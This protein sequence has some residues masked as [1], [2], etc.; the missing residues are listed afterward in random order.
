MLQ[1]NGFRTH[2]NVILLN[3]PILDS[4]TVQYRVIQFP[5]SQEIQAFSYDEKRTYDGSLGSAF[6]DPLAPKND[7]EPPIGL[8]Y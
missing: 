4:L 3:T 2:G 7:D 8:K 6:Y 1:N 5:K